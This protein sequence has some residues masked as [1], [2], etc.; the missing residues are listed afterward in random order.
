MRQIYSFTPGKFS[1]CALQKPGFFEW[2]ST[3]LA[4]ATSSE[5]NLFSKNMLR[6]SAKIITLLILLLLTGSFAKAAN[7]YSVVTNGNW[8]STATWSATS[9]GGGGASVPVVGDVAYIE[10][11]HNVIVTA[12]A[13]CDAIFFTTAAATSLTIN[14]GITLTI[15]GAVTIPRSGIGVNTLA[16]GAGILNAGSVSFTSGGGTN[17]HQITISTGTVTISGNVTQ[18]G[19]TGSASIIFTDAGTLNLGGTIFTSSTGTLTTVTGS[20]VNYNGTTQTV[21]DFTYYHLTLSGSGAKTTTGTSVNDILSMEGTATT[22]GTIATYNAAATLQYKGTAAQTTGTE[23][24]ATFAGTGGVIINN[25]NGVTLGAA[26]TISYLLT[27]TSGTLNMANTNLTV[28]SLTGS[29]NLTHSSGTAGARTLTVGSDNTS[30]AA[31]SGVISNG[32]ATSVALTK[33][34][35]GTLTLSGANTYTGA[36]TI[37][38]GALTLGVANALPIAASAGII[39]FAGG[40]PA[41]NPGLFNLGTGTAAAN[42]AGQLDFDV[43]TTVNLGSS[44]TNVY[45]FK[46]SNSQTWG[47]STITINNWTG[48]AGASG[49]GPKIYA[50]SDGSGLSAAQLAKISFTG[51][52]AGAQILGTGE[53]VPAI[54]QI[55]I[56][57]P[58]P[59]VAAGNIVQNTTNDVIYRFDNAVTLTNATISGLQITTA[60]TYAAA[61]LTNLKA[62]YSA[63][64]T[65]N[66]GTATLLSTKTIALGAGTQVFQSWTNQVINSG[67]TGYIFITADI[68][69]SATAGNTISVNAVTTADVTFVTGNKSGTTSAGGAQT[70]QNATPVNVTGPVASVGQAHSDLSWTNPAS[71]YDEIMIVARASSSV[72]GTPAGDGSAYSASLAFGSG[73]AFTGGGYVVYKGAT[74]PE[75]VTGLTNGTTYYYKFFTRKGTTWSAGIETNATASA[76]SSSND[77]FRSRANGDWNATGTWQSSYDGTTWINANSTPTSAANTIT[78]LNGNSVTVS[79]EDVSVDQVII[80]QGGTLTVGGFFDSRTLTVVNGTGDDLVNNGTLNIYANWYTSCIVTVQGQ[81]NNQGTINVQSGSGYYGNLN[82]QSG[83]TLKCSPSSVVTG[84]GNF[85]LSSGGTIEVGSPDGISSSGSTGNIQNTHTRTFDIA[86][87]YVYNGTAS[88]N[89]GNGYPSGLTGSLTINNPGNIVTLTDATRT[90]PS[91]TLNLF[92]GEFKT[93]PVATNRLSVGSTAVINRSE[94]TITGILQGLGVYNVNYTGLSKTTGQELS[95]SGLNN[96]TINLTSG[97]TLTL[98]QNRSPKGNL[99]ITSGIFDLKTFTMNSFPAAGT[100]S[101]GSGSTMLLG[102]SNFPGSYS[103]NTLDLTSLVNYY[104]TGTQNVTPVTYGNLTLSGSSAKTFPSG[105]TTVN[106]ILSMEGTATATI[107]GTLSYGSSATLQYKGSA[108]QTTGNEFPA[109]W[110]GTGGIKI[111]NANGVTLNGIRTISTSPLSIGSSVAN[112]VFND[113]GFQITASGTG[114]L[115]LISGMFK[116]GSASS[117]TTFPSFSTITNDANTTIEYGATPAQTVKGGIN[118]QNLTISGAGNKTADGNVTVNGILNLNVANASATQG[119]LEMSTFTLTMGPS[120]T[121]TGIG[122]VTGVVTRNSF[123]VNTSYSFGNQYTTLNMETG[124]T[125]PSTISVKIVLTSAHTWKSDAINRYY[126]I[127]QAGGNSATKATLN[128]HYLPGELHGLAE[129]TLD[130]FDYHVS[131]SLIVE[132]HSHS[133]IDN[134]QKWVGLTNLSIDYIA[135]STV[136]PSK[137]WTL[138]SS[139]GTQFTWMGTV[140]S[141]WNNGSNWVGASVPGSGNNVVI[142]DAT[143]TNNDPT[144]PAS[145]A[146]GSITIQ[147][148]GIVNGGTGTS[149]TIDGAAGAWSNFGSFNPGTST[150]TFTNAAAT[151]SG[152][153]DFNNVSVANGSTLNLGTNNIM[154]ITGN[155]TLTGS[156]VLI[157]STTDNSVEFNGAGQSVILPN[158]STPGYHS[159]ILSGSGN[160]TMPSSAMTVYGDFTMSGS[161]SATAENALTIAGNVTLGTGTTFSASTFTH[162]VSGNWTNNGAA[163]SPDGS[164]I[165]FNGSAAQAINGTAA[166][167]TF[168][169]LIVNKTSQTV[170]AGGSTVSLTVNNFTETSGNFTAPAAL[171]INGNATLTTGIFTAGTTTSLLGNLTNNGATFT[172]V[173]GTV[174]FE[175][176]VTQTIGGTVS[177]TFN[178]LTIYKASTGIGVTAMVNQTVNGI[179]NLNSPNHSDLAGALDMGVNT[180]TMGAGSTTAGTGDV[181]GYVTRAHAFIANTS[182]SFGNEFNKVSFLAGGNLPTSVTFK[183]S[184]GNEPNWQPSLTP[185]IKAIKREYEIVYAGSSACYA[186]ITLH[187]LNS[188]LNGNSEQRLTQWRWVN[189]FPPTTED[190]RRSNYNTFDNWIEN[191]GMPFSLFATGFG[192]VKISLAITIAPNFTW[193]GHLSSDWNNADNWTPVGPPLATSFVDIPSS[194]ITDFD[195]VI[196]DGGVILGSLQ[197]LAGGILFS[198]NQPIIITGRTAAW[199]NNGDFAAG[200]GNVAFTGNGATIGGTTQF[201]NIVINEG[202]VVSNSNGSLIMI[203]GSMTNNGTWYPVVGNESSTVEYNGADQNVVIPNTLTYS[204]NTLILSGSGTKT[205]PSL[206]LNIMGDLTLDGEASV[207]AGNQLAIS[208]NVNIGSTAVFNASTFNHTVGGNWSNTGTFTSGTGTLEFNGI[209]PQTINGSNTFN[210]LTISNTAG[211]T[212]GADQIVNGTINLSVSNPSALKGSLDMGTNTLSM[213]QAATNTGSGDVSGYVRRTAFSTGTVYTFGNPYNSILFQAGGTGFPSSLLWKISLGT[214]PSWKLNGAKREY[215]IVRTG[216]TDYSANISMHYL[217][218]ELNG[219]IEGELVKF[220]WTSPSSVVEY[221]TP[222]RNATQNWIENDAVSIGSLP[223]ALGLQKLGMAKTAQPTITWT[224][225]TSTDWNLAGNWSPASTPGSS[226]NVIIPDASSTPNDPGLPAGGTTIQTLT[227]QNGGILN[228]NGEQLTISGTSGAWINDNATFNAGS[229][230]NATVTFA[231]NGATIAGTTQFNNLTIGSGAKLTSL[232]NSDTRIGGTVTKTGTWSAAED[233]NTVEYN[234]AGQ[235]VMNP[236]G[237]PAG[238][239]NLILNGSGV[240]TLPGSALTIRGNLTLDENSTAISGGA[241]SIAGA[242]TIGSNNAF[243]AGNFSHTI[244]GN[245][246]NNGVFTGTGSTITLN[247]TSV[248]TINGSVPTTFNN[249]IIANDAGV[250]LGNSESVNGTLTLTSGTLTTGTNNLAGNNLEIATG[251]ILNVDE[252]SDV[253]MTGTITNDN[254]VDYSKGLILKSGGQLRYDGPAANAKVELALTGDHFHFI[255]PPVASMEIGTDVPSASGAFENDAFRGDLLAYDE[256]LP[257]ALTNRDL[258]WAY[259]DGYIPSGSIYQNAPF[260]DLSSSKGYNIH[261]SGT[262]VF[263]GPLN[264]QGH[265]FTLSRVG[266]GWNLVGNPYPCN[267]D[268][269]SIPEMTVDNNGVDKTLYINKDGRYVY[270]NALTGVGLGWTSNVFPP[271]QGFF[272]HV[273]E[274]GKFLDL[275][276]EFKTFAPGESRAKSLSA[277]GAPIQKIRLALNSSTDSDETI[278][279]LTDQATS[280]FDGSYD[281]YKLFGSNPSAPYIYTELSS[282]KYAINYL[283]GPVSDPVRVPVTIVL[284]SPGTYRIDVTQFENLDGTKV[285]LRHGAIETDLNKS[286]SYS[287]TSEAGTFTD[288]ELIF[289]GTITGIEGPDP[290]SKN[291]KTWYSNYF[292]YI[293]CPSDITTGNGALT[294]YD[295]QGKPVYQNNQLYFTPGQT[296]QV[297]VRLIDGVYVTRI[298]INN[299]PFISRIVV[300]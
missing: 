188:E 156:A 14:S 82:I 213:G 9:G 263:K 87:N 246:H 126:D 268:V 267:Y 222:N 239:Y 214:A 64:S 56:S 255:V 202:A 102:G 233:V 63:S 220:Q 19:S 181:T 142:P 105:T 166:N 100:F 191:I 26:K 107:T 291:L 193:N 290:G 286:R 283:P 27:M 254:G 90:I 12:N 29:G 119:C 49:S 20:T 121:T 31:Y 47:A 53:V 69:C 297:P 278:V 173:S 171:T 1:G 125:L 203:S 197:I 52:N 168:Y 185:V 284:K 225:A 215:E 85:V 123:A 224:G 242:L 139:L 265:S 279:G 260:S 259:F 28:G 261:Y 38:A 152:T 271:M 78:I 81:L 184:I 196:P 204:Y 23:F 207:V 235:S 5:R 92:A 234:G 114:T 65:F 244:S 223:V 115:H 150:V 264:A 89:T 37:N 167:Q 163:F 93:M 151:M 236:D 228:A 95:G 172:D 250:T 212:A 249:L 155:L 15:S 13:A 274:T 22:T 229:G 194:N 124:G 80:N 232:Q 4:I 54:A 72:T 262:S 266:F 216:N 177:N 44:G 120:A 112:S 131:G 217:D 288:F 10:G 103:T 147:S 159:L 211:V 231:T 58:N 230:S 149:L 33:T 34:G 190:M 210:N 66:A 221:N 70:I 118:Y 198:N 106:G 116:L 129:N 195:P 300:F 48:T 76:T 51:Y 299:K 273:T 109:T 113:G 180:L 148:G 281:A 238:Y 270:Y 43:N 245:F 243:T 183:I 16:V 175:G 209:A 21:G 45:Y 11:G 86:A 251:A 276:V 144:L 140:G 182:Y 227:I 293:N 275:P 61:D 253:S 35:T 218:T 287:F 41:L 39:Q 3:L 8:N 25:A 285:I 101:M 36:T 32:T 272:V 192:S 71:C 141:D 158:G 73:T 282:V 176:S 108:A 79:G 241:L 240:K 99:T 294:I 94:G 178:N 60:G 24:P 138:G 226:S 256:S 18:T 257:A 7:R 252:G 146:I 237:P 111:E 205:M 154:R 143:T 206:K 96:V 201:N 135:P 2:N 292:M 77:Y 30:P 136:F 296:I 280:S 88:Q 145:T 98:D 247:G 219:N 130:L 117:A 104:N 258:G 153:T 295:I 164:T 59:A 137:Y 157:A 122:D 189:G 170:S 55:T 67:S 40:T 83:G 68:P 127:I 208:G 186:N 46:A 57:S 50:G 165:I 277:P 17:R 298:L 42:S 132:D 75:T 179:L 187:Y 162:T 110:N 97:Q 289:G 134:T 74:S 91:G 248:Q 161:A 84:G 269:T 6:N 174:T 128:L 62:W 160:K 199:I 133:N 169:N 200:S